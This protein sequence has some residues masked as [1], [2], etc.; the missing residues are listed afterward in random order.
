MGIKGFNF[1]TSTTN[2]I[3]GKRLKLIQGKKIKEEKQYKKYKTK[4]IQKSKIVKQVQIY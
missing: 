2:K 1:H 4:E 3:G